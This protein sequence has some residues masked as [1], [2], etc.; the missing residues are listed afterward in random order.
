MQERQ[1]VWFQ[2]RRAPREELE[3]CVASQE[4]EAKL[5]ED[6]AW[7]G[8]LL[9]IRVVDHVVIAERGYYSFDE[10]GDLAES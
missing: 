9:G 8:E 10:A 4:T 7:A 2:E 3:A 6:I 1:H 5:R